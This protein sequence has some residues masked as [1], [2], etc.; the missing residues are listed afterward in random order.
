[1]NASHTVQKIAQSNVPPGPPIPSPVLLR[2]PFSIPIL[3][4]ILG[5]MLDQY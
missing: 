1:M 3:V 5:E 2:T 4:L